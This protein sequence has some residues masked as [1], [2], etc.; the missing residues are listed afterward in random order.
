MIPARAAVERSREVNIVIFLSKKS[1]RAA[2][3]GLLRA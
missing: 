1:R 3:Y 2:A